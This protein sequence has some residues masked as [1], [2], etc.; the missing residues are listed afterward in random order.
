MKFKL[1]N[2]VKSYAKFNAYFTSDSC[3]DFTVNPKFG[4]LEPYGREGT[5]IEVIFCPT[6]YKKSWVGKL[7]IETEESYWS[8]EV[9]GSLP[10]YNPPVGKSSLKQ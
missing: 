3:I 7:V 6:Q 8:Y 9:K 10:H 4:D 2:R 1:T 5:P